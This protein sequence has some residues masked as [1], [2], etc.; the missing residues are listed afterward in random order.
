MYY[1]QLI[2][3]DGTGPS[4]IDMAMITALALEQT[5][6][7]VG[8]SRNDAEAAIL[9]AGLAPGVVDLQHSGA[10]PDGHVI[11]QNP[12]PG[13]MAPIAS[14]VDIVV[15]L[16]VSYVTVPDVTGMLRPDA[17]T[18]IAS[19]GLTLGQIIETYI[20]LYPENQVFLQY[21]PPDLTV[22]HHTPMDLSVSLGVWTG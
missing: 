19:A 18:A 7:V 15:S 14:H 10:V 8:M 5:P 22:V 16:G 9:A 4:H 2:V 6:D 1:V 21:P 17:E 3:H 12:P 11:A 20:D 13:H